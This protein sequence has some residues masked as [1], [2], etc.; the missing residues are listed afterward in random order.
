MHPPQQLQPQQLPPQPPIYTLRSH[1]YDEI[2][3]YIDNETNDMY[4]HPNDVSGAPRQ[5][6]P[7]PPIYTELRGT[8]YDEIPEHINNQT[9]ETYLNPIDVSG[10]ETFKPYQKLDKNLVEKNVYMSLANKP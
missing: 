7:Q 10:P 8:I 4:V 9:D 1:L 5:L 3:E 2:P 6:Q